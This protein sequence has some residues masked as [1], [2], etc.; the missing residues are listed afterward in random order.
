MRLRLRPAFIFVPGIL[1]VALA[2]VGSAQAAPSLDIDTF[3]TAQGLLTAP[4]S[5]TV[6]TVG[7]DIWSLERDLRVTRISG[8]GSVT[9]QVTGGNLV[10]TAGAATAGDVEVVWD[11]ADAD[12]TRVKTGGLP[13]DFTSGSANAF[14]VTVASTSAAGATLVMEVFTDGSHSSVRAFPLPLVAS[15][16]SFFLSYAG[17]VPNRGTGATFTSVRAV[18]M[19]LRGTNV[20]VTLDAVQRATAAPTVVTQKTESHGPAIAGDVLNYT[21]TVRGSG[22]DATNVQL[23]DTIDT[24]TSLVA[25]SVRVGPIAI[26]DAYPNAD[27]PTVASPQSVGAAIGVLKNDRDP[28]SHPPTQV[29]G[30][31][32]YTTHRGGTAVVA[33]DGGF[34]YTAPVGLGGIPDTFTYTMNDNLLDALNDSA[35][36]T[37][38]LSDDAPTITSTIPTAASTV[39]T[40]TTVTLNFSEAVTATGASFTINCGGLQA[41]TLSGSGTTAITLTPNAPLP[42]GTSCTVTALAS[43]DIDDVDTIDPPAGLDA[44]FTLTFATDAAPAV[45]PPTTPVNGAPKVAANTTITIPFTESV[46]FS[47]S[48]FTVDCGGAQAFGVAGTGTATAVLTPSA[49]L[50]FGATCT[51]TVIAN[52]VTDVDAIDPPDTMVADYTFTFTIDGAP[53]VVPPPSPANGTINVA[54]NT[55]IVITFNENVDVTTSSF[56]IKCPGPASEPYAVTGTGTTT[57]TLDPTGNLPEGQLC[58]VTVV[59]NQVSDTDLVDPPDHMIADFTFSFGVKPRAVDDARNATGNVRVQSAGTGRSGFSVLTN[60]VGPGL[61]AAAVGATSVRGGNFTVA[62]DGTFTYDPPVGYAGADSFDYTISNVN[63]SDTGTVN[64]TVSGMLWFVKNDA[65]GCTTFPAGSCGRLTSPFTTLAALEAVNGNTA[66]KNNNGT[67]VIDP[68]AGDHIFIYFGSGSSYTGPLT[69]ENN[70]RVIGEGAT[71]GQFTG[72]GLSGITVA[73]DSDS[74]P[75]TGGSKPIIGSSGVGFTLASNN[76]IYGLEFRNTTGTAVNSTTNAGTFKMADIK[77]DNTAQGGGS[78]GAGLSFT[79]GGTIIT[80][81]G[82]NTLDTRSAAALNVSNTTIGA[83]NLTFKSISA[84]NNTASGDPVNGIVLNNTGAGGLVVTGDLVT[85]GTCTI[86][87]PTCTGGTIQHTT[88]DGLLLTSTSKLSLTRVSISNN[89]G[90]GIRGTTLN[91]FVL[92]NSIVTGNADSVAVDESGI[93]LINLSGTAANGSNPTKIT[94]STVSQSFEFEMQIT[95]SSGTLTDLQITNSA[96]SSNGSSGSHGD[97]I[98]F[99]GQGTSVMTLTVTGSAFTGNAPNTG[100]AIFANS[101]GTSMNVTVSSSTF[102]NNN[103]G[104][105]CSSDP[106]NTNLHFN[107]SNNT[108]IGGRAQPINDFQNGNPPFARTVNGTVQGNTIGTLG[109]AGSGSSVGTGID[110]GNE[111]AVPVNLLINSSNVIQEL[112]SFP[113][114]VA[115]VGLAGLATGGQTTNVTASGNTIRN[116]GSRG[117]TIQDNQ[118][119]APLFPTVCANISANAFSGIAGQAGNGQFMRVRRL[120]GT[121]NVTQA[122]PT[123]AANAAE[124]D[125]ANGFNDPTKIN[126]S[127]TITFSAPPCTLPN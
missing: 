30:P 48:S 90:S 12:A 106:V 91:G 52:Q 1:F 34:T 24:N 125:D 127:G 19:F 115:N 15:S 35:I 72:P 112:A 124:L 63:G 73:T 80:A 107:V 77:V 81:G 109:V 53:A 58:T 121:Y 7:V 5:S 51:V 123:A 42:A 93:E 70:Q 75:S 65:T 118:S 95:N 36:V 56:T 122:V 23:N 2:G 71:T 55:N 85:P 18:R 97:L 87:T 105:D 114:I 60:D 39:A 84:G 38:T 59:A 96:F 16:Q 117:I 62:G 17:F 74:I 101:G 50:P 66:D 57:I 20:T 29:I 100:T 116:I 99:L 94:N 25:G 61:T 28:D 67:T 6:S 108:F 32:T 49:N 31:G 13:F 40:N 27:V 88:G 9:A 47:T 54:A 89:L 43:G 79:A 103:A 22:G 98:N 82:T 14:Q 45:A 68:D 69:L 11:G 120:N 102:T 86:A 10:F 113:A 3:T 119:T 4:A 78:N 110:L 64:I 33:S 26:N 44:N 8:A 126:V 92:D 21:V 76:E 37:I 104:V 41:F 111:G 83:G 46:N